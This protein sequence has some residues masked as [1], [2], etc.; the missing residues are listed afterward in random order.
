MISS[1]GWGTFL[2][3]GAFD[4][5]IAV[6]SFF[7]LQETKGLS[8]EAIAHQ[9]FQKGTLSDIVPPTKDGNEDVNGPAP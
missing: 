6:L 5:I 8:L 2:L 1:M 7:F 9:Q 4:G 3:W